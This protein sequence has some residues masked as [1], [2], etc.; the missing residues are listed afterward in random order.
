V[1]ELENVIER[2][3]V[4]ADSETIRPLDLVWHQFSSA[5]TA[6]S[7]RPA[8][9]RLEHIEKEHIKRT[10]AMFNRNKARTAEALGIDRKTLRNKMRRYDIEED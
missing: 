8:S 7:A 5:V 9:V 4:L 10:L 3:V 1:R 6:C 2:A